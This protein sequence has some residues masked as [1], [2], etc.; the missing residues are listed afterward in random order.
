MNTFLSW[1][2][3]SPLSKL[4]YVVFLLHFSVIIAYVTLVR[5]QMQFT[6]FFMVSQQ[7]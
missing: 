6:Q 2:A 7:F 4:T 3:F 1:E 5:F